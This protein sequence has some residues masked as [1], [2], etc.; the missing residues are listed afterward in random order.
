M[1]RI[2]SAAVALPILLFTL[3]SSVPYYFAV[4]A[5]IAVLIGLHEFYNLAVKVNCQPH[6]IPGYL[7]GL[8]VIAAFVFGKIELIIPVLTALVIISF[9]LSL[10][11]PNDMKTALT[12]VAATILS[13]VY[14]ALLAGFLVG[15]RMLAD[16]PQTAR[17]ASKLLTMFFAMV[18]F[19]DT[20][21]FYAGRNFGKHKLA[22]HIS[23]GKTVEGFVGG[24]LAAIGAGALCKYTFFPEINLFH[25]LALGGLIGLI[26]PVGDLSESLLKRGS[27]VKDSAAIMPGHGGILDRVD[28]VVFCAPL[29][30]YYFRLF[31][32]Y[33]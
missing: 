13:V 23:P 22:P 4:L 21:A 9:A 31:G 2:L 18:I 1:K 30:Y 19:T 7:A 33:L 8:C 32:S 12:S 24:L 28:S 16:T 10:M 6:S 27:D 5:A 26:G 25:A 20:G 15:V 3:W 11:K 14:I 17:L 29:L